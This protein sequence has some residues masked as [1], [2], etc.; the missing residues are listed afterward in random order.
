MPAGPV[1]MDAL[2]DEL[3]NPKGSETEKK[4]ILRGGCFKCPPQYCRCAN[5]YSALP[6]H[7]NTNIG[8]RVM[9]TK[10]KS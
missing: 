3:I 1:R 2:A 9:V 8:F 6:E 10:N 4:R 5:R 7:E